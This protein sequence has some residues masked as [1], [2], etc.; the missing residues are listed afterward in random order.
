M[1]YLDETLPGI[2]RPVID[3]VIIRVRGAAGLTGM[4][5]MKS[6]ASSLTAY[7]PK[8]RPLE[9]KDLLVRAMLKSVDLE[10]DSMVGMYRY[11]VTL[12]E[13]IKRIENPPRIIS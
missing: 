9:R 13:A 3:A 5:S 11:P 8:S 12:Q 4:S 1:Q 6:P 7:F 2:Q 10:D